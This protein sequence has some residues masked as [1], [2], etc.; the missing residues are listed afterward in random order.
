MMSRRSVVTD[1]SDQRPGQRL[2]D[3]EIEAL[4]I[5]IAEVRVHVAERKSR[6]RL[7]RGVDSGQ[8][9]GRGTVAVRH[10]RGEGRVAGQDRARSGH[11]LV[12][13]EAVCA[14]NDRLLIVEQVVSEAD[15]RLE[16]IV[17]LVRLPWT[18]VRTNLYP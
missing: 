5:A 4:N 7:C 2:L 8:R 14:A 6:S 16:I 10:R 9:L 11:R 17:L 3:I 18:S 15:P 12:D 1:R 13:Q